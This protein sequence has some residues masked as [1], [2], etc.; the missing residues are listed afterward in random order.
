[1]VGILTF[2]DYV[3][4]LLRAAVGL[5]NDYYL[6]PI[7]A[8]FMRRNFFFSLSFFHFYFLFNFPFLLL[9]NVRNGGK[10]KGNGP[11]KINRLNSREGHSVYLGE[12]C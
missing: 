10:R 5:G 2:Y 8:G 7:A 9:F 3:L 1:M 11:S 4:R 6:K 12:G